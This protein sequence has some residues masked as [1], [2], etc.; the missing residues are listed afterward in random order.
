MRLATGSVWPAA[1][2]HAGIDAGERTGLFYVFIQ[3]GVVYNPATMGATGWTGWVAVLPLI[4]VLV[5]ARRLPVR[6][7]R[8]I[9]CRQS[10]A[11]RPAQSAPTTAPT[12]TA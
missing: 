3:A 7:C 5:L 4:G 6:H 8:R 12:A 2:G 11:R 10:A 1:I 9:P